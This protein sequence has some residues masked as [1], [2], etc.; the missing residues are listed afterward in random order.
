[1]Y[2]SEEETYDVFNYIHTFIKLCPH[3]TK[4]RQNYMSQCM[5][6]IIYLIVNNLLY[7]YTYNL[8]ISIPKTSVS[9]NI[10]ISKYLLY[11]Q[12]S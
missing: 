1:M 11:P 6:S 12:I 9:I 8:E 10:S 4:P 3:V 2:S 7:L 5:R